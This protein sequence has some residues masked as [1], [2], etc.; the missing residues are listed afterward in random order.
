MTNNIV[1]RVGPS[2]NPDFPD[3]LTWYEDPDQFSLVSPLYGPGSMLCWYLTTLS[4]L[5]SWMLHPH[6]R[7]SGS[8]DVDL[9]AVLTLPA[10]AAGHLIVLFRSINIDP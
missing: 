8:I 4:V 5:L 6:K 1:D 7:A 9:V 10:V 2:Q 3:T